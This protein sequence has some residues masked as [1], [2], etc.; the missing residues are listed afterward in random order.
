MPR[1]AVLG[2]LVISLG[3]PC[4]AAAQVAPSGDNGPAK[5]AV[6]QYV[7]RN[8]QPYHESTLVNEAGNRDD[9][10][11]HTRAKWEDTIRTH[12]DAYRFRSVLDNGIICRGYLVNETKRVATFTLEVQ[13]KSFMVISRDSPD[14]AVITVWGWVKGSLENRVIPKRQARP[15]HPGVPAPPVRSYGL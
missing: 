9:L 6:V 14:G 1:N 12:F 7:K 13:G 4:L 10:V 2:A 3:L 15:F 8:Y 5:A 11:F